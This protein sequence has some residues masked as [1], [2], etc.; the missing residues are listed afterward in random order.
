MSGLKVRGV[1]VAY[2]G[3][4]PVTAVDNVSFDVAS[5]E[6]VGLLGPSGCGKSS[7]LAAIIGIEPLAA[8]SVSWDD[9]NL[10]KVPV[11]ERAFG[12]VFQ[13]GQLF[14]HRDVTGNIAFGLDMAHVGKADREARVAELLLL[15]G[16]PGYGPRR[17]DELS[18]G[19]RQRVALARSLAPRPKLLLLDEPLS[20][21]DAELRERLA[22]DVR[23]ILH[24]TG[25]TA[26][27]V[28]HDEAEAR[29]MCSRI[30]LMDRG[31][32]VPEQAAGSRRRPR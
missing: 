4:N 25:T 10:A 28:T 31:K 1:R 2:G 13:D 3:A 29:A 11:H 14:P 12:L 26:I 21:L 22:D 15:V 32:L 23:D 20:S 30:I 27:I 6:I 19:E 18:G 7:L 5:G 16:L 9:A 17:V 8:G 24:A